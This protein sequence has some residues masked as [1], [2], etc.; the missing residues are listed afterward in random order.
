MDSLIIQIT[1]T[2]KATKVG[3]KNLSPHPIKFSLRANLTMKE[4]PTGIIMCQIQ[5]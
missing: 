5:S 3:S 2:I 1:I 4:V